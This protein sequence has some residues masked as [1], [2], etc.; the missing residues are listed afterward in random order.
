MPAFGKLGAISASDIENVTAYVLK[1][2]DAG[3]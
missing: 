2:A 1:K 3:W